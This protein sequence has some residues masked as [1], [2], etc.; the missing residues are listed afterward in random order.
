MSKKGGLKSRPKR[1]N[2]RMKLRTFLFKNY[3]NPLFS[4]RFFPECKSPL[5]AAVLNILMHNYDQVF[6]LGLV[7]NSSSSIL[8]AGGDDCYGQNVI[9]LD[10]TTINILGDA[11]FAK[12]E[13][14]FFSLS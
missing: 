2:V 9:Y 6:T 1:N 13:A 11:F 10:A 14:S 8:H 12:R 4:I 5:L 3:F 7:I